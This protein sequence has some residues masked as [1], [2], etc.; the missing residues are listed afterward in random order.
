MI[1]FWHFL[2]ERYKSTFSNYHTIEWIWRF[3]HVYG[4]L[5]MNW[6]KPLGLIGGSIVGGT[7][8]LMLPIPTTLITIVFVLLAGIMTQVERKLLAIF[9]QRKGP[10][11]VGHRGILQFAADALKVLTKEVIYLRRVNG[12]LSGLF[13]SFFFI[14][15]LMTMLLLTWSN[16][17]TLVDIEYD[18]V[19]IAVIMSISNLTVVY[20][21]FNLKNK[22]TQLSANRAAFMGLNIDVLMGFLISC[23]ALVTSSFSF[24]D[25]LTLTNSTTLWAALVPLFAPILCTLLMDVGKAPFDLVEAE[26]ELIMGFF[27]DYSGFMF[28]I[29]LLGEYLHM[30]LAAY[31]LGILLI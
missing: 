6:R 2:L 10:V 18:F 16:N 29:F 19:V 13:P 8:A 7:L 1:L 11:V 9:Q 4:I 23:V 30:F 17:T 27:I 28:I 5:T 14:I 15:N 26:T 12:L 22:Y 24:D 20:T 3:K 31:I 21:G 25:L